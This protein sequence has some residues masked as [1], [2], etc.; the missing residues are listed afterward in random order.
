VLQY[1]PAEKLWINP[2][3]G[4]GMTALW[5]CVAKLKEMA[6]GT[7]QFRQELGV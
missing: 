4:F 2:D 5:I 1:V 3:C 6:E 7:R